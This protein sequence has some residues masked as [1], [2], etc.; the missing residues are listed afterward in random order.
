ML[1][2][3]PHAT[4]S[5]KTGSCQNAVAKALHDKPMAAKELLQLGDHIRKL[6]N[7][8]RRR[9]DSLDFEK[10][11]DLKRPATATAKPA[12]PRRRAL[13]NRL[14]WFDLMASTQPGT[15]YVGMAC[16]LQARGTGRPEAGPVDAPPP[17][18]SCD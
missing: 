4:Y 6:T 10:E 15:R 16:N 11:A 2:G 7:P 3:D 14:C 18:T 17:A 12:A 1:H 13:K 5:G 8:P 9:L